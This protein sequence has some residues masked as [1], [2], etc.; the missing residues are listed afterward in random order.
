MAVSDGTTP[1]PVPVLL[2]TGALGAGKTSLINTLLGAPH[3]RALAV[4]V[5]DFG[6][7]N[8]DE[9]VLSATGQPV[10]GLRNGCICC[11]LQGD[12]LRT[13]GTILSLGRRVDAIV[14]EASGVSDPRGIIEALHDPVLRP[15]VGLDAVVTVVDAEAH[16]PDDDLWRAQV[17][18]ADIVVLSKTGT[19]EPGAIARLRETLG[20]MGKALVLAADEG[21]GLPVDLL[22]GRGFQRGG[23]AGTDGPPIRDDRFARLEWSSQA[24]LSLS[25]FRSTI[26]RL[27]PELARAKGFV[28]F[29]ERPGQRFM[30]QLVGRRASL[31]P[32]GG[33]GSGTALVFI[34]SAGLFDPHRAAHALD[35]MARG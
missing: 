23:D 14:I 25:L 7:I 29:H 2:V 15:A 4:V 26:E 30:F 34:G 8:I 21:P 13:L 5:N 18:A 20:R 6:A 19:A 1:L 31:T 3:G 33:A 28:L 27:A 9:A 16:H 24:P 35:A 10:Y 32:V 11:S 17:L 12:L 22:L